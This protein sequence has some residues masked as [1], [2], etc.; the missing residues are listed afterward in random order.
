M[1]NIPPIALTHELIIQFCINHQIK[2]INISLF[3]IT[4]IVG[5]TSWYLYKLW[6]DIRKNATEYLTKIRNSCDTILG[7]LYT[8]NI[9][10]TPDDT[11]NES[12]R[13]VKTI[14]QMALYDIISCVIYA[15][16]TPNQIL[17]LKWVYCK[18]ERFYLIGNS[19]KHFTLLEKV[20]D[21]LTKRD[22]KTIQTIKSWLTT[23]TTDSQNKS[24]IYLSDD[25]IR[26]LIALLQNLGKYLQE[27]GARVSYDATAWSRAINELLGH[28]NSLVTLVKG[29]P[30]A[31]KKKEVYQQILYVAKYSLPFRITNNINQYTILYSILIGYFITIIEQTNARLIDPFNK[32]YGDYNDPTSYFLSLLNTLRS[33]IDNESE[34]Q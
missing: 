10:N 26:N 7:T 19:E 5:I 23:S 8:I 1:K 30:F 4:L 16:K 21:M 27:Q 29:R 3:A 11:K 14:M 17:W 31:E 13:N 15:C 9:T 22:S 34:T 25:H 33:N 6:D 18:K 28:Y 2:S 20:L 32:Q 12:I 24:N